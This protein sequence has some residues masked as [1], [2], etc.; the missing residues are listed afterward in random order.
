MLI[1]TTLM[2]VLRIYLIIMGN[3]ASHAKLLMSVL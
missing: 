3:Y 1:G 2:N